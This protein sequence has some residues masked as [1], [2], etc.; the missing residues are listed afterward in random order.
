MRMQEDLAGIERRTAPH[1]PAAV[2]H[3]LECR[4]PV[5]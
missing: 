1:T 2:K 4:S 3:A 5:D